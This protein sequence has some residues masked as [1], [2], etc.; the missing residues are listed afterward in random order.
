MRIVGSGDVTYILLSGI[1]TPRDLQ[2]SPK[3]TLQS[4][5]CSHLDLQTAL[6]ICAHPDDF[7][8]VRAFV[9]RTTAQ[10]VISASDSKELTISAWNS[11]W[12]ILLLGALLNTEIGF[13]LQ[14]DMPASDINARTQLRATNHHMRGFTNNPP[15]CLT[16]DECA[17][18]LDNFGTARSML[19]SDRFQTAVHCLSSYRW[20]SL[21]QVQMA[22]LWA[23]IEGIFGA[24]TEIRFRISLY[25]ARFLH[26]DDKNSQREVFKAIKKLYDSRSAAVHGSKL[27]SSIKED[28]DASANYLCNILR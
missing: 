16:E 26:P 21:P 4:A 1:Y 27:K 9:A 20:H 8:V 19:D 22:I 14:S 15:H 7:R 12:D 17:W 23:G 11:T 6:S 3:I 5:D 2:L 18:L 13:N 10:L 25:I 24:S 28:V